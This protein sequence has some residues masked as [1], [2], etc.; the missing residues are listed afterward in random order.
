VAAQEHPWLDGHAGAFSY[1]SD[2]GTLPPPPTV[3]EQAE[4]ADADQ[5]E[6]AVYATIISGSSGSSP[7]TWTSTLLHRGFQ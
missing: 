4:G 7:H 6:G 3:G 1:R 2:A 5:G